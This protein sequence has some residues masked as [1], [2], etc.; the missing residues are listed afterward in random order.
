MSDRSNSNDGAVPG[1]GT[2]ERRTLRPDYK[3]RVRK[4]DALAELGINSSRSSARASASSI[5][6]LL[7]IRHGIADDPSTIAATGQDD[8]GPPLSKEGKQ[9]M[10]GVAAGLRELVKGSS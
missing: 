1:D 7:V 5:A 2:W 4:G 6:R 9:M 10:K 8:S 3:I